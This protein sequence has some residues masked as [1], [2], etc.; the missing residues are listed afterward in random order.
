MP[1]VS[2][3]LGVE[4]GQIAVAAVALPVIWKLR[5]NPLFVARWVPACSVLVALLGAFWFV[6]RVWF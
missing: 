6:Q 2:F 5:S 3:N 4:L 1:L